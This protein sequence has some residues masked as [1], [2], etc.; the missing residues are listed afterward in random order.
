MNPARTIGPAIMA[1]HYISLWVYIV[2]PI[3]GT[4]TGA[5][6]YNLI[7]FTNKPLH[8]VIKAKLFSR[9]ERSNVV[10]SS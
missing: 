7:R 9:S 1:N 3:C 4:V 6:A 8:G 2:G 5:W 10:Y